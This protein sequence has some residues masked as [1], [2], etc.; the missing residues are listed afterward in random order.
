VLGSLTLFVGRSDVAAELAQDVFVVV[1]RDWE[2]VS[3]MAHPGPWVHRVAI[4]RATTWFRRRAA[5]RRAMLRIGGRAPAPEPAV[6]EEALAVRTLVAGLPARLRAPLV[7][8]YYA[9]LSVQET[10]QA[11]GI[12]EGTVKTRTRRGLEVLRAAGY[13]VSEV[14]DE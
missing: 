4:N 8:R 3:V 9:D 14:D 7:L 2:R 10:A 11:L 12:P 1:C 5:E 13:G 6:F